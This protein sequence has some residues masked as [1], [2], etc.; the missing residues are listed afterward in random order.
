MVSS[1]AVIG[2]VAILGWVIFFKEPGRSAAQ[3]PM[4]VPV[5]GLHLDAA[6]LINVTGRGSIVIVEFSDYQCPFCA[7]YVRETL[8]KLK[9]DLIEKGRV[10]YVALQYPLENIHPLALAASE[11]S[12]CA[13]KQ[14]HFWE[15]REQLFRNVDTLDPE[16]LLNH[17]RTIGLDGTAFDQCLASHE[18]LAKIR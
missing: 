12:E 13:A 16:S 2:A 9:Q 18:T 14:G 8:P 17:A 3:E 1:V 10:R 7:K 11:A 4:V 15:M 6:R 5:S